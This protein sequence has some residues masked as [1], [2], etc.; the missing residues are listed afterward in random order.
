LIVRER[1]WGAR[2]TVSC[3]GVI[4][5]RFSGPRLEVSW[6]DP[7]RAS[8]PAQSEL[9]SLVNRAKGQKDIESPVQQGDG[10]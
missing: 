8:K 10:R 1:R 5:A 3:W 9:V 4:F 7:L 2:R 6:L